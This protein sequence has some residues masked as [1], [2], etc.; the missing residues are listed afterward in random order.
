MS[1]LSIAGVHAL[2][3]QISTICPADI[4]KRNHVRAVTNVACPPC[5]LRGSMFR[6]QP[7]CDV[8]PG[9][10]VLMVG[11]SHLIWH[12]PLDR[13]IFWNPPF[14]PWLLPLK[15]RRECGTA[16]PVY[17]FGFF[18]TPIFMFFLSLSLFCSLLFLLPCRKLPP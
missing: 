11:A 13:P 10:W 16:P 4:W 14:G 12:S 18:N 3:P 15:A 2:G 6:V 17:S 1:P 7:S 5:L 8:Q 9:P